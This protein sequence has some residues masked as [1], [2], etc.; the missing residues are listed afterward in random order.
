ME[1]NFLAISEKSVYTTLIFLFV[2]LTFIGEFRSGAQVIPDDE[3]ISV[4]TYFGDNSTNAWT[5]IQKLGIIQ[6]NVNSNSCVTGQGLNMTTPNDG[7]SSG[8]ACVCTFNASTICHVTNI[9]LKR[10]SLEGELPDDFANLPFLTEINLTRSFL[11]GT[12]PKNWASLP[13]VTLSLIG[14]LIGGTIPI[15]IGSISTLQELILQ[16][17]NLTGPLPRELGNLRALR[18]ILLSGNNFTGNLPE[19]FANLKSLTDF[20]IA[21]SGITGRIPGFIGEWTRL[22]TLDMQ[23]TNMEGPIPSNISLL[24]NLKELRISDLNVSSMNFP[25]LQEL[26]KLEELVLRSCSITGSIPPYIGEKL[27]NIKKLDLSF[28]RLTGVIPETLARLTKLQL[29]FLTNNTLTGQI[30]PWISRLSGTRDNFDISY[31]NFTGTFESNCFANRLNAISSFPA[32]PANSVPWCLKKD[33]PC[34]GKSKYYNLFVDCGG[35]GLSF[36]GERYEPD[37]DGM[38]PSSFFHT[39]KWACSTTGDYGYGI[40]VFREPTTN[41]SAGNLYST[42]RIAPFSLKYYGRC[43]R[44]GP[45]KVKLH[46]AEIMFTFDKRNN[47]AGRRIFDIYIQGKRI[48]KDFNIAKEAGGVGK[49]FVMEHNANVTGSTL[50]I[51]LYWAGKGTIAVPRGDIYG[52]LISAISVTPNFDPS[53]GLSAGTI[54][55]IVV[56]SFVAVLLVLA[57]LWKLGY[58]GGKDLEDKELRGLE[59]QTG[60]FTLRQIKAATGNF[61]PANKIGEGGFGPVYK[62]VLSDGSVIAV[63]QLSSKSKQGNREFVNEI[64]MLSALQHP[65]LV[66]LFGCCI[67]GNQLLLIYEY[68][69]NN[70]LARALFGPEDGRLKLDWPTRLKVCLGIARGLAYLHE[71][72]RLKIVHRDMKATNVLLDKDLTAKISDFGLA[73]LDDEENTHISTRIAGTI[74]YMAPEYAMRGYLTEKADVYSFGIVALEIVS[75][76]SNSN[77]RPKEEYLLDWAYVLQ[78]QGNL[79]ELVDPSLGANFSKNEAMKMLNVGLLCSNPS[80]TLRPAMSAV[81]SML[82]GHSPVQ[83]PLVVRGSM[84]DHLRLKAFE[85]LS[86]DSQTQSS[87]YSHDS[88]TQEITMDGPWADSSISVPVKEETKSDSCTSKLLPDLYDVKVD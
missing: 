5:N 77:F 33:L 66:R 17:N 15:E 65:H 30:S 25:D 63:K 54:A 53:T 75:G 71:E 26:T 38:G 45:Y 55:G 51:H 21:G 3:L 85:K 40:V 61:D 27:L 22:K 36:E 42:A 7:P 76:Q 16:D 1:L 70:S 80:P 86:Q 24:R 20:R 50:E 84:T 34:P 52:P 9:Q 32:Q 18:R 43:L 2:V 83:A 14:N 31:N 57:V 37:L 6:W 47:T 41:N 72:S 29:M 28:N 87:L 60:Y 12:I 48:W 13:L 39:D 68:M 78:E 67:E 81:V 8:V 10:L 58:L 56:S 35:S 46:F 74:G 11:N 44:Q 49:S 88:Q 23:G 73:K 19:T 64:G 79:L 69:E 4:S 59:L 62:G 82:E